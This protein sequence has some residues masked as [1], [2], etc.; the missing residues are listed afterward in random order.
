M[1]SA[2]R[3]IAG[4]ARRCRR[5]RP[6]R[7][8]GPGGGEPGGETSG[9]SPLRLRQPLLSPVTSSSV[10][11]S[12]WVSVSR[13]YPLNSME[14]L[15]TPCSSTRWR[16]N[17]CT[18]RA[19]RLPRGSA[20]T[21]ADDRR[22]RRR[23]G[24]AV[25]GSAPRVHRQVKQPPERIERACDG[26]RREP[27]RNQRGARRGS[28]SPRCFVLR[29]STHRA[30]WDWPGMWDASTLSEQSSGEHHPPRR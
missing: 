7:R 23:Q 13:Q 26:D 3:N 21:A 20:T 24:T 19:F 9:G 2:L 1:R 5:S 11:A 12:S 8:C 17:A 29:A 18:A 14:R 27:A 10:G 4:Q 25:T 28:T 6:R 30:A 15:C 16:R 22:S